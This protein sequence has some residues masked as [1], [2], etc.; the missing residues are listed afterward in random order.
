M[1]QAGR[2]AA[3][4]S[5]GLPAGRALG[6]RRCAWCCTT[7]F[8]GGAPAPLQTAT[9][10]CCASSTASWLHSSARDICHTRVWGAPRGALECQPRAWP[11]EALTCSCPGVHQG[12]KGPA[13]HCPQPCQHR[14][15]PRPHPAWDES[16]G[17]VQQVVRSWPALESCPNP[18]L[19][20][21][22]LLLLPR[23]QVTDTSHWAHY[24]ATFAAQ[25]PGC[26]QAGTH[27]HA[28]R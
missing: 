6:A 24:C 9:E 20:G 4:R 23:H 21:H 5:A 15:R 13:G 28:R 10:Y 22:P 14:W 27:L 3:C 16:E 25:L 11:A 1:H 8:L 7:A 2:N 19:L 17:Q 26:R 12:R 18:S